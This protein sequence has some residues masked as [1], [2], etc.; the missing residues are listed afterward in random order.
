MLNYFHKQR[1][2]SFDLVITGRKMETALYLVFNES[3]K[4]SEMW[5]SA[6]RGG[7]IERRSMVTFESRNYSLKKRR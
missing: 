4:K 6:P 3:R 1:F 2:G 5:Q 7:S